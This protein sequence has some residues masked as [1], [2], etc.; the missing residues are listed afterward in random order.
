MGWFDQRY[1]R[2]FWDD[3][4]LV[5]KH[6]APWATRGNHPLPW[7]LHPSKAIDCRKACPQGSENLGW[8]IEAGSGASCRSPNGPSK[9]TR[10]G[11]VGR[12]ELQAPYTPNLPVLHALGQG[13]RVRLWGDRGFFASSPPKFPAW[14]AGRTPK[15]ST[16]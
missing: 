4:K 3:G 6:E 12:S 8:S 5:E 15:P 9:E 11:P 2:L 10:L 13:Y 7:A 1:A 14:R 16:L